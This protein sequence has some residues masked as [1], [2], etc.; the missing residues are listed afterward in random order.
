MKPSKLKFATVTKKARLIRE[1]FREVNKTHREDVYLPLVC[2]Q[3]LTKGL[4][5]A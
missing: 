4:N 5:E 1:L 2:P 3:D